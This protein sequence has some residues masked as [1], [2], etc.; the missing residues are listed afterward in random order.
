MIRPIVLLTLILGIAL[1]WGCTEED[2]L[3]STTTTEEPVL[4]VDSISPADSAANVS[5]YTPVVIT[6]MRPMDTASYTSQ[7]FY[8]SADVGY[9][10]STTDTTV[11]FNPNSHWEENTLHEVEIRAGLKDTDGNIM[12]QD[13][14]F[15]FTT[16]FSN[17]Y[18][19][20]VSPINQQTK[21]PLNAV[22]A[23]HFFDDM[24]PATIT[25]STFYI[26]GVSGSVSYADSTAIFTPA[27][28]LSLDETYTAVIK[29][30]IET[31]GGTAIGRDYT[32]QFSTI[33][34]DS[35]GPQVVSVSPVDGAIDIS[36]A[37]NISITFNEEIKFAGLNASIFTITGNGIHYNGTIAVDSNVLIFDPYDALEPNTLCSVSVAGRVVDL[38]DNGSPLILSWSFTTVEGPGVV[39][40]SPLNGAT[41]VPVN[42]AI[43]AVFNHPMYGPTINSATFYYY[44]SPS[45][46][47]TGTISYDAATQTATLI[48]ATPLEYDT[49]YFV[50]LTDSIM[51]I[52]GTHLPATYA[53]SFTTAP[54]PIANTFYPE[55]GNLDV[56]LDI[57]PFATFDTTIMVSTLNSQTFYL[58]EINTGRI[59]PGMI[60]Y[61]NRV[62]T[63]IPTDTLL[64]GYYY[65]LTRTD[66]V[67][68]SISQSVGPTQTT[69]FAVNPRVLMPLAIGNKWY[70]GIDSIIL[71]KDTVINNELW[72]LDQAGHR[73]I[74]H[75]Y[76]RFETSFNGNLQYLWGVGQ[77]YPDSSYKYVSMDIAYGTVLAIEQYRNALFP[78]DFGYV[79]IAPEIGIVKIEDC[80]YINY[81]ETDC[82]TV[83]ILRDCNFVE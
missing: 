76:G 18:I 45:T 71:M 46:P 19:S 36:T 27:A 56:P 70:Y 34:S 28:D 67:K 11:R 83:R 2:Q 82:H 48:P 44:H 38:E 21:V 12:P 49:Q 1:I 30:T 31:A 15:S 68:N 4:F 50:F 37:E 7:R 32:W 77:N 75:D 72:Y 22:V 80:D 65:R 6:F 62:A 57:H 64:R 10:L 25:P 66:G 26:D 39:S 79:Y 59:V 43:T 40:V 13:Y 42:S 54:P 60:Q 63:F 51:N 58:T 74:N 33:K 5:I 52:Y 8:I 53:W 47:L 81:F 35:I 41:G 24:N 14:T 9:A 23:A 3:L 55:D 29:S 69:V 20:S 78:Y 17:P 16:G 73:Y 61:S